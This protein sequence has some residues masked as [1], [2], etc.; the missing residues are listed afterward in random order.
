[1]HTLPDAET[2]PPA[3]HRPL[4]DLYPQTDVEGWEVAETTGYQEE[5]PYWPFTLSLARYNARHGVY[6]YA[7]T[8]VKTKV[9]GRSKTETTTL[10]SYVPETRIDIAIPYLMEPTPADRKDELLRLTEGKQAPEIIAKLKPKALRA[11]LPPDPLDGVEYKTPRPADLKTA[12]SIAGKHHA[13]MTRLLTEV[14]EE[15]VTLAPA[16]R[17]AAAILALYPLPSLQTAF[18]VVDVTSLTGL[19]RGEMWSEWHRSLA[20]RATRARLALRDP[21][22]APPIP[23][24]KV[25]KWIVGFSGGKDSIA[26]VL[27]ILDLG[28]PR[29]KIELWHHAI[30]P[31]EAPFMDWPSTHAYCKSFAEALD[32]P[33]YFS[34]RIGGFEQEML[35]QDGV[36]AQVTFERGDHGKAITTIPKGKPAKLGTRMKFPQVSADLS[37]RWC[38]STLKI[39]VAARVFSNDPRLAT[40]TYVFLTGERGEESTNRANYLQWEFH[41]SDNLSRRIYQWRPVQHWSEERVWDAMRRWG[42][43]PHPAYRIGFGRVSCMS[44]IFG[45]G[46]QWATVRALNRPHFQKI[47]DYEKLF[48]VTIQR[49]RS[50]VEQADSGRV[51]IAAGLGDVVERSQDP[52]ATWEILMEPDEWVFPAGAFRKDGG[53]T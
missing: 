19:G 53:P 9:D 25:D 41:R 10:L 48:G 36:T 18:E 21:A 32:L 23:M 12:M 51:V 47:A 40:G 27:N 37:V 14:R 38:S 35:K 24:G 16:E 39:D 33:L 34:A 52:N 17:R 11:L 13:R 43:I 8:K 31:I 30:D 29:H 44:C 15:R 22:V 26:C 46:D 5:D 50:V 49:D 4:A 1:M 20:G 6:T 28:V 2:L 3:P 42:I 45:N 7:V